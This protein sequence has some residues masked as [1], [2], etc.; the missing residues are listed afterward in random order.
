MQSLQGGFT[1]P[2]LQRGSMK[3]LCRRGFVKPPLVKYPYIHRKKDQN[4]CI[5][6]YK[7]PRGFV[8]PLLYRGF[9]HTYANFSLFCY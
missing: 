7:A 5:H 9:V 8:K 2:L 6:K 4:V 1:K 3:P